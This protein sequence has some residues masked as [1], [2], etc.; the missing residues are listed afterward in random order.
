MYDVSCHVREEHVREEQ[1]G[2]GNNGGGVVGKNH[3]GAVVC[4]S[5]HV[6]E[7]QR[8]GGCREESYRGSCMCFLPCQGGTT[9][10]GGL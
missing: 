3:I 7:E 2:G 10:G 5:C 9:G 6:R 8:G 4:V 1:R